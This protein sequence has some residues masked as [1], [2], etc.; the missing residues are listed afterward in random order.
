MLKGALMSEQGEVQ[1]PEWA[2]ELP[3]PVNAPTVVDLSPV[4]IDDV[5]CYRFHYG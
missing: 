2:S 3:A 1:G 5:D 4:D